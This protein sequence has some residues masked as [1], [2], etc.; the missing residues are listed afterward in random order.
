[1]TSVAVTDFTQT[2]VVTEGDGIVIVSAP[3]SAVIVQIDGLGP[4]GPI[5]ATGPKSITIVEPVANDEFTLFHTEK[6]V[7]LAQVLAIVRGTSPSVTYELRYAANRADIGTQ[8]ISASTVTST[9]MGDAAV[10]QNQPIPL[11]FFVWVKITAV[12]GTVTEFNLSF[13]FST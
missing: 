5:G 2:V 10:I 1:M 3:S 7:T 9:T 13:A 12:A 4:Q 11:G 8:A 6:A